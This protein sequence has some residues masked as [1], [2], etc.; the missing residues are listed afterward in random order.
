MTPAKLSRHLAD[1]NL[2]DYA[3]ALDPDV[4]LDRWISF[5]VKVDRKSVV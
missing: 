2:S 3:R 1:P 5:A 4:P